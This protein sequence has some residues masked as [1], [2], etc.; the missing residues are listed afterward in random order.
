MLGA[1]DDKIAANERIAKA[2]FEL[3]QSL[4]RAV[5]TSRDRLVQRTFGEL[6]QLFDGPHATPTRRSDGPYF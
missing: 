6:G 3:A 2:A 4:G 5:L 1:L